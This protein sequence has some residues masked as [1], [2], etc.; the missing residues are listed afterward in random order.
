MPNSL[1]SL[2]DLSIF[3]ILV[4]ATITI[5]VMAVLFDKHYFFAKLRYKDNTTIGSISSLIGIIY[6][7]LVGFVAIYLV[8]NQDHASV[9][10]QR[11]ASASANIFEGSKWLPE[12]YQTLLQ[13]DITD[14][15]Q[16]V[17]NKEWP[18]MSNF[19]KVSPDGDYIIE[20]ILSDLKPYNPGT[21]SESVNLQ[22]LLTSTNALYDARH[23]R[24]G[25]SS[26]QLSPELWEVILIGTILIIAIN[27]AF[28]VNFSLHLFATC[29]FAVMAA[30]M[31]FLLV[32][33][34]R[35]FQGEFVVTPYAFQ[36][37]LELTSSKPPQIS[38]LL[39]S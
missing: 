16:M 33:L 1:Y 25:I 39:K 14:Y 6:G 17:L 27:Y 34:D 8:N 15:I 10:V 29:S 22:N 24:I 13:K 18:R 2:S 12:P 11:E 23:A 38:S 32:T 9:A 20:K 37:V 7:V 19:Q 26:S 30:S 36:Q 35:P 5:S 4:A 3:L 28:R 21:S 31:L